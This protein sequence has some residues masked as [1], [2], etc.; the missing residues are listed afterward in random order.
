ML[1]TFLLFWPATVLPVLLLVTLLQFFIP[2]NMLF[3]ALVGVQHYRVH[4]FATFI[5]VLAIVVGLFGVARLQTDPN[6][7]MYSL[8]FL[9]CEVMLALSHNLKES[10]NRKHP[11]DMVNMNFK[12]SV[13]QFIAFLVFTPLVMLFCKRYERFTFQY[14]IDAQSQASFLEFCRVYLTGGM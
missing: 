13:A 6:Q 5:I 14:M 4:I 8:M 11:S 1:Y 9:G 7:F 3:R 2:M 10:L 12:V